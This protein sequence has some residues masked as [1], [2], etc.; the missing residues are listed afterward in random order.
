MVDV[1]LSPEIEGVDVQSFAMQFL[2]L[3]KVQRHTLIASD[4]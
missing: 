3:Q 2:I 4:A 1:L